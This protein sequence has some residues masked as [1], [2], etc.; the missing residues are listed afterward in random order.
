VQL[1]EE[2]TLAHVQVVDEIALAVN[3]FLQG[4]QPLFGQNRS[5]VEE[6]AVTPPSGSFQYGGSRW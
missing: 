5:L 1:L 6:A 4:P 3:E 2:A